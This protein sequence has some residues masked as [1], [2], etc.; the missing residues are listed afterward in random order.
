LPAAG[1]NL[2]AINAARKER[3]VLLRDKAHA[4]L[5]LGSSQ[6]NGIEREIEAIAHDRAALQMFDKDLP[7][8]IID[9]NSTGVPVA[10]ELGIETIKAPDDNWL[11][12]LQGWLQQALDRSG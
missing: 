1:A 8:A 12:P 5:L 4:F 7:C 6:A 2:A 3:L 10:D 11:V 9:R